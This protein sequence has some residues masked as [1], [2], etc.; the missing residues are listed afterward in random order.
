MRMTS[1]HVNS[2]HVDLLLCFGPTAIEFAMQPEVPQGTGL[3][4]LRNSFFRKTDR[5][6]GLVPSKTDACP[7]TLRNLTD[8]YRIKALMCEQRAIA[9]SDPASRRNWEE[10][11]R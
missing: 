6:S 2:V 8:N 7:M 1:I 9:V 10:L 11:A 4:Y 5:G 3:D